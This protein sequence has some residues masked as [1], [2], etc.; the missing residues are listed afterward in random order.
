MEL[1]KFSKHGLAKLSMLIL[2]EYEDVGKLN[3]AV[4]MILEYALWEVIE[5]WEFLGTFSCFNTRI[6]SLISIEMTVPSTMKKR[7]CKKNESKSQK[8]CPHGTLNG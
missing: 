1:G 2:G 7:I 5:N 4:F 6:W 8:S 3:Q